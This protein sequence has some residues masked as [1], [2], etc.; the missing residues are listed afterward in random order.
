MAKKDRYDVIV[1]GA[2]PGD[3]LFIV[4]PSYGYMLRNCQAGRRKG[5][6]AIRRRSA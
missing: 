3:S 2:G 5:D 6:T 4:T 1:V